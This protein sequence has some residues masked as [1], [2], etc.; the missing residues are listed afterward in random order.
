MSPLDP[1][2]PPVPG[3]DVFRPALATTWQWQLQGA[4]NTTY[5][6][7]L[8]DIDLFDVDASVIADLQA[9]GRR[10]I[11]YF[12]AGSAE[13]FRP[14]FGQFESRDLGDTLD[15]FDDERHVDVRSANVHA[16]MLARLDLAVDKGCDGVEPDNV[17]S[18]ADDNGLGFSATDQLAYNRFIANESHGRGLSVALKNGNL[19]ADDLVD[20]FDF[21]LN[22]QCHE[23]S[24]CDVFD[25]F[26]TAGKPILNAEYRA[27]LP[28]A[29][30]GETQ[31][32]A[33]AASEDIRT[34]ILP[35]DLD[36]AFRIS[37]D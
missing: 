9:A 19:Q 8:Y 31:L 7:D 20:Y 25:A 26:L 27:S 4:I 11:C 3:V 2:A 36:D 13:D 16:I 28:D 32:C 17:Q 18:F 5:D 30:A 10:V 35:I 33:T 29:Q 37:C 12:S 34:L 24:E 1:D 6:A 22:E 15:G 23:F 14:D 21:E